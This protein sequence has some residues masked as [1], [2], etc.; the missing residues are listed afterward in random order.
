M[1]PEATCFFP[2]VDTCS[3]KTPSP[4]RQVCFALESHKHHSTVLAAHGDVIFSLIYGFRIPKESEVS[5]RHT[6]PSP[7]PSPPAGGGCCSFGSTQMF[8]IQVLSWPAL[9]HCKQ[10]NDHHFWV[11]AP[12]SMPEGQLGLRQIPSLSRGISRQLIMVPSANRAHWH[13]VSRW[14]M[15]PCA[16]TKVALP[17]KHG[18]TNVA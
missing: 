5:S 2:L 11:E 13:S 17:T 10:S 12:W 7:W 16:S 3:S 1:S 14:D 15:E 6:F 8:L 4:K 18:S 9:S